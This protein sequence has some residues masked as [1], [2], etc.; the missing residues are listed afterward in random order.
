MIFPTHI[1]SEV[2]GFKKEMRQVG[3]LGIGNCTKYVLCWQTKYLFV[4]RAKVT[5]FQKV[6]IKLSRLHD[7]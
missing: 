7:K 1:F 2:G 6:F 5:K 3:I 4:A